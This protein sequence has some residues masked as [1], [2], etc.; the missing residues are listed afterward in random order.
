MKNNSRDLLTIFLG[1][2]ALG[3][4]CFAAEA[5]CGI[6]GE[7]ERILAL[8][9][10]ELGVYSAVITPFVKQILDFG[11]M[12]IVS[13]DATFDRLSTQAKRDGYDLRNVVSNL[14][15][16]NRLV[17]GCKEYP[18]YLK[19]QK[20]QKERVAK[21]RELKR[22]A[23]LARLK[24]QEEEERLAKLESE[25]LE[26]EREAQRQLELEKERKRNEEERTARLAA[27]FQNKVDQKAASLREGNIVQVPGT[28]NMNFLIDPDY[29]GLVGVLT[30]LVV[31]GDRYILTLRSLRDLRT[32]GDSIDPV[33]L[34]VKAVK[35]RK[36][37]EITFSKE[38][39]LNLKILAVTE[40]QYLKR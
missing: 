39:L 25:R 9:K 31:S 4:S 34:F 10:S 38:D 13:A 22:Q 3:L 20:T 2:I 19:K 14:K 23:E 35:K 24:Q 1:L 29:R 33:D 40:K 15:N 7:A 11:G 27:E 16:F 18:E 26:R 12:E 30:K 5:P 32:T 21:E 37:Y 8:A 28:G 36:T 6:D 17:V